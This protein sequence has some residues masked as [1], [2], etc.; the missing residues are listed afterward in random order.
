MKRVKR[1][2]QLWHYLNTLGILE[3]GT[4]E[5]IRQAKQEYRKNYLRNY[6]KEKKG[7]KKEFSI[8]CNREEVERLSQVAKAHGISPS[9]F[10]KKA[11]FAYTEKKFVI[12]YI[13]TLY[14]IEQLLLN[15][16][17][18]IERIAER[19]P[20]AWFKQDRNYAELERVVQTTQKQIVE[21]FSNPPSLESVIEQALID[22]PTYIEKLKKIIA[23][24][25]SQKYVPPGP[26]IR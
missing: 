22:Q 21:I 12:P 26:F 4:E 2:S 18:N 24:Y 17:S 9:R 16:K 5:Q 10:L 6:K 19:E 8:T 1:N 3:K 13:G 7:V 11:A 20:G 25:D 23:H 14:H 15:C